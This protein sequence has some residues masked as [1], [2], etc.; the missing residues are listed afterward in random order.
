[1]K[2]ACF[3]ELIKPCCQRIL[4]KPGKISYGFLW[5][6]ASHRFNLDTLRTVLRDNAKVILCEDGFLRSA[7]T[8]C[9]DKVDTKYK[10]SCSFTTDTH[11]HYFDAVNVSDI[12]K[13]LNDEKLVLADEQLTESRNLI[14]IITRLKLSKYNHQPIYKPEIGSPNRKK[15]LVVDQS[16]GDFSVRRGLA[17][18]ATFTKMLDRAISENPGCDILVKTH[19]DTVTGNAGGYYR[20]IKDDRVIKVTFPINPYSL[21]EIVDKVYVC[22]T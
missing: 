11:A 13:M 7:T 17:G 10:K 19:P 6:S 16:Y 4:A 1:M 12:E 18:D 22:C 3:S 2:I 5:G 21:L 14:N 8:W 20:K 9:D 15:V